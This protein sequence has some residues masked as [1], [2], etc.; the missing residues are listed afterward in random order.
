MTDLRSNDDLRYF[1]EERI[2]L[3][4]TRDLPTVELADTGRDW[5]GIL[6]ALVIVVLLAV[7]VI[8]TSML[9][10]RDTQVD[11]Q[12]VPAAQTGPPPSLDA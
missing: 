12:F 5:L 7:Q 4:D 6:I 9:L 2:S 8:L 11:I 10:A 1:D 3:A